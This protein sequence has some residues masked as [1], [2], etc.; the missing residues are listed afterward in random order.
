MLD[1][2]ASETKSPLNPWAFIRVSNEEATLRQ[3]LE[4]ILGAISRGVIGY[5]DCIDRSEEIILSFCK[6]HPSFIPAKYPHKIMLENPQT[7]DNMLHNYYRFVLSFIPKDE[8][9]IKI[10]VDHIYDTKLLYKTFY[11]PKAKNHIVA[12]P[13][14]NFIIKDNE[15][16]IQNNGKDGFIDGYDQ[17]LFCNNDIDFIERKTSKAAQW[18][19]S[20]DK[21]DILYSEQ[22]VLPKD[23]I[24]F[25]APLMQWHFPAIKKKRVNFIEHLDL[26]TLEDFKEKNKYL[27]N[28]K[29]PP[30]ML[31]QENI[32]KIYKNF[33]RD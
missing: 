8:W 11:I 13:R 33:L 12:Y 4:S 7:K 31:E 1:K 28:S 19:D 2:K 21:Q 29:I 6:E 20:S 27:F 10:D 18:I 24:F 26:L 15:I 32:M 9:V 3:S 22:Q 25:N 17:L 23:R 14:I 30:Y 5:N 16:F